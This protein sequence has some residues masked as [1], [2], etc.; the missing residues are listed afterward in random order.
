MSKKKGGARSDVKGKEST[1]PLAVKGALQKASSSPD[2]HGVSAGHVT[3]TPSEDLV[4]V[5]RVI[6][7]CRQVRRVRNA[8]CTAERRAFPVSVSNC[9]VT[10]SSVAHRREQQKQ[11]FILSPSHLSFFPLCTEEPYQQIC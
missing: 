11:P 2:S 3:L 5:G 10:S 8:L 7:Q 1:P 9:D 6:P 4:Y